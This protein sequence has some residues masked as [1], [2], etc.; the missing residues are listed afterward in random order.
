MLKSIFGIKS[1]EEKIEKS[2]SDQKKGS[3]GGMSANQIY[4]NLDKETLQEQQDATL[5]VSNFPKKEEKKSI[6]VDFSKDNYAIE[7]ATMYAEG[8]SKHA[9]EY[10]IKHINDTKGLVEK[11]YWYM[12]MDMYQVNNNKPSF[13]K[14]ALLFANTFGTSP[15]SWIENSN[16]TA[17]SVIASKN[18]LILDSALTSSH[19][20][21]LKEFLISA[22]EEKFCR[23]DVSRTKFDNSDIQGIELLIRTM[24]DLRKF[25][26]PSV[27]MG[28]NHISQFCN[29]YMKGDVNDKSLNQNFLNNEQT[30]W[31]LYLEILQWKG[32]MDEFEEI[33]LDYAMTFEISPPGWDDNGIMK[34][35][36]A[37]THN[38][39]EKEEFPKVD[40][41][42][43]GNNIY[44]LFDML[45]KEFETKNQVTVDFGHVE[46]IDFAAAGSIS[47]YLQEMIEDPEKQNKKLILKHPN[48]CVI[49]LLET[50]GATEFMDIINKI[51]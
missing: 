24:N 49:T 33:A 17:S 11:R 4:K 42:I 6:S 45:D 25:K 37:F 1:K 27:L 22:R 30:F 5:V 48:E 47:H 31:L 2:S 16:G 18:A 9:L 20:E 21:K 13:E 28:D 41:T 14:A 7:I 26:I 46:R 23:I 35:E 38:E 8:D 36:Q 43:T 19:Q 39:P 3:F 51:R 29:K 34:I 32:R 50:V 10:L 44:S 40:P 15:P 12:L